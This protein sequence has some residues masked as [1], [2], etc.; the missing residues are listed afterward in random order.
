MPEGKF[1]NI[2]WD[3]S[4][5]HFTEEEIS[6]IIVDIKS[7]LAVN[8]IVSGYTMVESD[9]GIFANDQHEYEFKDKNDLKRFWEPHFKNVKVFETIYNHETKGRHNLYFWAS[10]GILPFSEEWAHSVG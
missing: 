10:D 5:E 7:R 4:I 3:A 1:D 9:D 8:G 6:K 2:I